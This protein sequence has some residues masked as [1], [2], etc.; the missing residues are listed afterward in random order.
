MTDNLVY[1]DIPSLVGD[2]FTVRFDNRGDGDGHILITVL[3]EDDENWHEKLCFSTAWLRDLVS[4]LV[5]AEDRL[6]DMALPAEGNLG[7]R[8]RVVSLESDGDTELRDDDVVSIPR[9]ILMALF[10]DAKKGRQIEKWQLT[11]KGASDDE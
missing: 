10:E 9:G 7:Y 6:T 4:L 5:D 3:V 2:R 1:E 11:V 8:F